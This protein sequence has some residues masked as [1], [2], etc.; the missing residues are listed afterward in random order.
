MRVGVGVAGVALLCFAWVPAILGM[1]A[2]VYFPDL[3][4][5]GLALPTLLIEK[6]PLLIGSLGLA[7]IFSAELSSADAI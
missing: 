7:A 2:R 6:T 1:V 4:V 3:E 5:A